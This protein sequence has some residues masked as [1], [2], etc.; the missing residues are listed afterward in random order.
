V[1]PPPAAEPWDL[2]V[3]GGTSGGVTAAVQASR[4]G[5]RAVLVEP[6]RHV[7]GLTSGGLGMTDSGNRAVIGGLSREFYRRVRKHYADPAAWTRQKPEEY[8]FLKETEDA[9]WR[10]EPRVAEKILR[11]M[12]AEAKVEVVLGERLDLGKGVEKQGTRIVRIR[13]ES[14]RIFEGKVFID[15]TYEGDLMAKAGVSYHVGREANAQYGETLNGVQVRRA[16]SHQFDKPVDPYVKPGDPSSGLLPGLHAGDPGKDGEADKRVQAY[17]FRMCLTDDPENRIPFP[18]PEGYDA[19][20][21]ELFLRYIQAGWRNVWGNHQMMPNRKTDTNNHG[22]FSTD[23]IGANYEYPDGDYA[24]RERI[25]KDH[26]VYQ[27]GLMWFLCNDPRVPEDLR[28]KISAWGLAKDEFVDQG[29]WPHQLYIREARRMVSDYVNSELDCRRLRATPESVGMGSYNMDSHNVQRYVDPEGRARNEGDVQV[30]PGGPYAISYKAIRPRAA[31]CAN[32]LVPVCLSCTHIAYGSIRMEPVFMVLGQSAATAAVLA[33]EAGSSVQDVP[34]EKLRAR[35]LAD[36]QVLEFAAP[37]RPAE[38]GVAIEARRLP[39][40]VVDDSQATL[41]G[42]WT[43]SHATGPYV[44]AGYRHDGA[45]GKGAKSARFEATLPAAGR[46]EVR[47]AYSPNANRCKALPV[48]VKHA[49][50]ETKVTVDQTKRPTHDQVFVPLGIWRFEAGKAVLEVS[51]VGTSG[52]VILDAA[53][54]VPV[55]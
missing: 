51:T 11:D 10:F 41:T 13:M 48:T 43:E 1:A 14:G 26:E 20:R 53:A 12:L 34:Y 30:S 17:C 16:V 47:L 6:S 38:A 35:L 39:G 27:K 36:G 49:E 44:G 42:D 37:P 32:L 25:V 4:M 23:H 40:V 45:A 18:K 55:P 15:A 2:V 21:Y 22:A 19:K 9:L 46:Y 8:R 33:I 31:E 3:Y 52:H 5:K 7:G 28:A 54:W 29:G 50:G 24:T